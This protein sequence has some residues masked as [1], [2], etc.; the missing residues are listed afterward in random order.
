[1]S[2]AAIVSRARW[3]S[4]CRHPSGGAAVATGR[5]VSPG[6]GVGWGIIS[7][8][9]R[10]YRFQSPISPAISPRAADN[11]VVML[12]IICRALIAPSAD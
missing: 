1:L 9:S 12:L 10:S 6:D 8:S 11:W 4:I 2:A 7:C 5:G 3:A